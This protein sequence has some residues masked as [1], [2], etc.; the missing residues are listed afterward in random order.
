MRYLLDTNIFI[1]YATDKGLLSEDVYEAISEPDAL[2]C[3][4][5]ETV[6]ELIIGYNNKSFDTRMW[7]TAKEMVKDIKNKFFIK[8]LPLQEEHMMTY[9]QLRPYVKE[10]H[11]DP[12]DHII[13]SHAITNRMILVSSD[14]S[15]PYYVNYG[16]DL[17][18]NEK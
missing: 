16:L 6:R 1:Y 10:G 14:Q 5:I 17:L 15:F 8:I 9:A 18:F 7:K 3:V 13:I 2:L 12:S 4:S 11:K